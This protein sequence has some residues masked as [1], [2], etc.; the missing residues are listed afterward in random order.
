MST[1]SRVF[2]P[3]FFSGQSVVGDVERVGFRPRAA[4]VGR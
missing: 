1:I 4:V 2:V 3:I